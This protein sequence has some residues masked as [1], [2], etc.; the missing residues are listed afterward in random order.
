MASG[1]PLSPRIHD[2]CLLST[3]RGG[4]LEEKVKQ[5]IRRTHE[6]RKRRRGAAPLEG[7]RKATGDPEIVSTRLL[8]V[9]ISCSIKVRKELAVPFQSLRSLGV[10]DV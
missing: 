3:F 5:H 10:G 1:V 2:A 6:H 8:S 9:E 4:E 7:I